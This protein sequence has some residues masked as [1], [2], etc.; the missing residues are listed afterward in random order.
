MTSHLLQL[1]ADPHSPKGVS[2]TDDV[3]HPRTCLSIPA[4]IRDL[5]WGAIREAL[6]NTSLSTSVL[7][8]LITEYATPHRVQ[9]VCRH[10]APEVTAAS[11]SLAFHLGMRVG[12]FNYSFLSEKLVL[13][14]VDLVEAVRTET[15]AKQFAWLIHWNQ[16][17]TL[18]KS[19]EKKPPSITQLFIDNVLVW[20][21]AE[22]E[23]VK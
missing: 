18:T 4:S 8:T 12:K 3:L 21:V 14:H 20:L 13:G 16:H 10:Y 19:V 17:V 9:L 6:I 11:V 2:L 7:H 22:R 15:P 23:S 1:P 5:L